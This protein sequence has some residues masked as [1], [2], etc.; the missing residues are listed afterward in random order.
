MEDRLSKYMGAALSQAQ[1]AFDAGE[2]P[3]GAA[4]FD[5][6]GELIAADRNRIAANGATAHAELLALN[7]AAEKL[8]SKRLEGC[9]LVST[10][11]PCGMCAGAA[12]NMRVKEI[13][14]GAYDPEYGC[15][16][17]KA[18]VTMAME[19]KAAIIGGIEETRC[20]AL[21]DGFFAQLRRS[22]PDGRS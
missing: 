10:L 15:C 22:A 9:T 20:K 8:G 4:V 2:I 3:V 17:S 5:A 19:S 11:E 16:V 6:T 14:F 13:V 12:A 21:L 1:A 7:A 18:A